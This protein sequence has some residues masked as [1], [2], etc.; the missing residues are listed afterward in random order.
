MEKALSR[1]EEARK[2]GARVLTLSNLRLDVLPEAIGQL[3]ELETLDLSG[4]KLS[5]LPEAIGHL[6]LQTPV[7]PATGEHA[8]SVGQ[9]PS[10]NA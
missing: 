5:A 2:I 3:S 7:L 6:E 8:P 10:P 1:I 4:N 9:L